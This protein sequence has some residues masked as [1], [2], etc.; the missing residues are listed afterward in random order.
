MNPTLARLKSAWGP[1]SYETLVALGLTRLAEDV[2]ARL[3]EEFDER[4]ARLARAA[5]QGGGDRM[6][7][8]DSQDNT[9]R[10][11]VEIVTN[12]GGGP[13][14]RLC[15]WCRADIDDEWDTDG[16]DM[17]L[18]PDDPVR[19]MCEALV[20]VWSAQAKAQGCMWT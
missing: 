1:G 15:R 14:L 3:I 13:A 8:F 17:M 7:E 5:D 12:G 9:I 16:N 4:N 19:L 20:P 18:W 11:T 6:L 2:E 10:L